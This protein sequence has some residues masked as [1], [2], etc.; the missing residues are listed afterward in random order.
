MNKLTKQTDLLQV[1]QTPT[2]MLRT[3]GTPLAAELPVDSE[4]APY[5]VTTTRSL[6]WHPKDF[7]GK[8][9]AAMRTDPIETLYGEIIKE[10]CA[11]SVEAQWGSVFKYS[12]E[13]LADAL[14][15]VRSY[16]ISEVEI[17]AHDNNLDALLQGITKWD[18]ADIVRVSYLP[19]RTLVVVP[20]DRDYLGILMQPGTI[21]RRL[22]L[23]H[24]PSRGM[25]VAGWN[26]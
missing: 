19:F 7:N 25:A 24:N 6:M 12:L 13:G 18:G 10:I 8:V 22:A 9:R 3:T 11:T 17:L 26:S 21:D 5:L 16:G 2:D 14:D 20:K 4:T 23:V 1:L 15:Y